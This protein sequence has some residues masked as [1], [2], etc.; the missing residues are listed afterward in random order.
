MIAGP[1]G[2][3]KTTYYEN[4]LKKSGLPYVGADR[5]GAATGVGA[6]EAAK[7]AD[8]LRREYVKQGLGF[9]AETVFS[10]PTGD[11]LNFLRE[12]MAAGY[13]VTL[14]Y[15]GLDSPGLA[16][17]RVG[18]RVEQG[19]HDVPDEKIAARYPRS[20]A[21][22]AAAV[23]FV[24]RV[25]VYDNSSFDEPFRWLGEFRGGRLVRQATGT[26]PK[27]AETLIVTSK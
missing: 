25:T 17:M 19:G 5:I 21:N 23:A 1:N 8:D 10:D 14:I 16:Q 12:A 2:A 26:M 7:M 22:L 11:K 24:S 13:E 27:W 18:Q 15:I 3:G 4:Y 20:L 6:Y 9:V